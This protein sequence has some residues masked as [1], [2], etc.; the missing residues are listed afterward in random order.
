MVLHHVANGAGLVVKTSSA[1]YAEILCHGDFHTLDVVAVPEGFDKGV[2]ETEGQQVVYRSFAQVVV[3]AKN[4]GLIERPKQ[5]LVQLL[6]RREIVPEG[7]LDD[8]ARASGT[9]R[10]RQVSH[11]GFEQDW[12]DRQVVRWAPCSIEFF[13]KSCE[14]LR[15]LVVAVNIAQ[16]SDQL[17]ESCGIDAAVLLQ[18]VF[19]PS[20]QL[21]EIPAGFGDA[22]NRNVEMPALRHG[23]QRGENFLV[24]EVTCG[25]KENERV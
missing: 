9:I 16:Q 5:N 2:G 24:S 1:L 11:N 19:R 6:R 12:G 20:T 3:N 13:A 25:A 7:F 18:A 22:D 15:L 17:F 4:I 14:S 21:I 8:D 10:F 23:L